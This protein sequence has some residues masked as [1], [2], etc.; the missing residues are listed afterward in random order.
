MTARVTQTDES[1]LT[2]EK[3]GNTACLQLSAQR[4]TAITHADET[5][6]SANCI[7]GPAGLNW[8]SN[9]GQPSDMPIMGSLA[10]EKPFQLY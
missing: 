7:D 2:E 5:F 9:K 1:L 6:I 3:C 8:C 10:L 4:E